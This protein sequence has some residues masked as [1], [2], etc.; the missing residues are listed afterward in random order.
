MFVMGNIASLCLTS[1]NSTNGAHCTKAGTQSQVLPLMLTQSSKEP[2]RCVGS[3][4]L[5]SPR[6]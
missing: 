2:G 1:I 6:G 4:T 5:H 3:K